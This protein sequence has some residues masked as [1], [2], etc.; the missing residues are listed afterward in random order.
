MNP[1]PT[2]T[3]WLV[4]ALLPCL[5]HAQNRPSHPPVIQ[6]GISAGM[7]H[8]KEPGLMQ[9]QGPEVGLSLRAYEL[10]NLP[11]LQL[12]GDV[13][14][15]VQRYNSTRTGSMDG[16]GNIETRW[17]AMV[18]VFA[19][20]SAQKGWYAGLGVHT[21]WND[22]RGTSS[23]GNGGYERIARQL[24]V[25]VRYV[26]NFWEVETGVLA[27]GRHTSRLSQANTNPPRSD[28]VNTQKQGAYLQGK[29]NIQLNTQHVL[30]PYVRY[31]GLGD[32]DMVDNAYEPASQRW[33]LGVVWQFKSR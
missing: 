2:R 26:G 16:V 31:T 17:R 4:L 22:L 29:L 15:G 6:W 8:Y 9:L 21:L 28:V 24:W 5:A 10:P 33:Q 12:E 25:P 3:L 18:P 27:Y 32:S 13:F 23:T 14:L 30:S 20:T 19:N 7:N 1:S 11:K